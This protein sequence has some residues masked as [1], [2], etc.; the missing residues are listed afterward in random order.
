[1]NN[2]NDNLDTNA[3]YYADVQEATNSHDY[4]RTAVGYVEKWTVTKT[5]R[6][7]EALEKTWSEAASAGTEESVFT[8][9]GLE[10]LNTEN[11]K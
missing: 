10:E 8:D 5:P 2:W 9:S 1:M 11:T 4:E 6:D 3:W 7:W